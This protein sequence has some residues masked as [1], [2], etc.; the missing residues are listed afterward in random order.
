MHHY[1]S[2]FI[3]FDS[4]TK[5]KSYKRFALA[6]FRQMEYSSESNEVDYSGHGCK[7]KSFP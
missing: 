5:P 1:F 7:R 6:A 3:S 4:P 2:T